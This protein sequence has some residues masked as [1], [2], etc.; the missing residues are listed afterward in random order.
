[1]LLARWY[2]LA[3]RDGL[4]EGCAGPAAWSVVSR[5]VA[6]LGCHRRSMFINGRVCVYTL[7]VPLRSELKST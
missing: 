3:G 2:I 6:C 7:R 1:M 5:A 4:W